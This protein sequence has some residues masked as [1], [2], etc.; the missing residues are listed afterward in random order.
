VPDIDLDMAE[1]MND[2]LLP[3]VKGVGSERSYEM[4]AVALQTYGGSGYLQDYPIEQYLRDAEDRHPLRRHHRASRA[5]T[6][7]SAR[8]S[9]ISSRPSSTSAPRSPRPSKGDEGSGQLA[10]ERELLGKALEDV[11]AI[12]G[13][14]GEWAMASQQEVSEIYKVGLNTT[15]LLMATGDLVIGWP[16]SSVRL[17]W[18]SPPC[19]PALIPGPGVLRGQGGDGSLVRQQSAAT[20]GG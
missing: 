11:Q 20:A 9:R 5:W 18:P 15:R 1:R 7:S 13:K 17:R 3:I 2:L 12:I 6:S 8:W 14:L 10:A 16:C 19:R 4:L